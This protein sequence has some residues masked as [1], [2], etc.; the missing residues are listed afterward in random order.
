MEKLFYFIKVL[1]NHSTACVR[2]AINNTKDIKAEKKHITIELVTPFSSPK[3]SPQYGQIT[4]VLE[5][6][7]LQVLQDVVLLMVIPLNFL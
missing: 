7:R 4:A 2:I 1:S 5:I 6:E 3:C